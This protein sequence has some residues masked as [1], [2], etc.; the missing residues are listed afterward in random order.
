MAVIATGAKAEEKKDSVNPN[1]PV[2]TVIKKNPITSIKDQNRSGTCWDYSTLSFFE[3]EIL[4]KSGKTYDLSEAFVANKTY[5]DRAIQVV[6]LHGDCQFS[7]GGSAYDPL[8]CLE[9]YGIVPQSAE[10]YPTTNPDDS[11]FNFNEFFSVMTPYVEAVAKNKAS[12]ISPNWK[13]GLQ[14]ILDSYLGK[15]PESFTYEG[16]TYTPKSFA[17]SLG[18]NW[19]DYVSITSYTH[20]PFWTSFAVEVQDNWRNPQSYNV[21][22]NDMMRI[23]D[24][25]IDNGYTVAWGGDVSEPGFTRKGLA[26]MVDAKKIEDNKGSDMAHWLGLSNTEK[27]NLID[28]LG[29]NVPEVTPTQKQRQERFDDWELTDDHGMLIYGVAKDQKGKEYYMV[30]NSWGDTGDYHG[31]WYMTKNFIAANTMDFLVNKNAIPKDI[32]KKL[33]I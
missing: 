5:M 25:A 32:R 14:G 18:L 11:L 22:M 9:H 24:N 2:F 21:P 33:G 13:Q 3:A 30:K 20:H 7:E 28:S 26:Y 6:R 17:E 10:D 15:A 12:R 16:K 27:R 23:I 29:V 1:K 4:K 8:Y 19:S 31:I